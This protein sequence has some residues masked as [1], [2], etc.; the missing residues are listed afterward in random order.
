[1]IDNGTC[2]EINGNHNIEDDS[3]LFP[4]LMDDKENPEK[5]CDD[6][7]NLL[8]PWD[9]SFDELKQTMV[10]VSDLIY[11]RVVTKSNQ[12][13][14][15]LPGKARLKIH[16]SGFWENEKISFDSTFLRR[17]PLVSEFFKSFFFL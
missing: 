9:R 15:D 2:F 8:S 4:E 17:Q 16:Y 11:K 12:E 13:D 5:D 1:L 3:D 10:K 14:I 6:E 7:G